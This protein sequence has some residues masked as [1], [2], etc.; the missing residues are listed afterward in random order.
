MWKCLFSFVNVQCAWGD[1]DRDRSMGPDVLHRPPNNRSTTT[2]FNGVYVTPGELNLHKFGEFKHSR[3]RCMPT[4][5]R[6]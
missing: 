5:L 4:S 1:V 3:V 2:V 6:D